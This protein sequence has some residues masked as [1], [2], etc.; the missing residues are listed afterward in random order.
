MQIKNN[1]N[2]CCPRDYLNTILGRECTTSEIKL[3]RT[4]L[5]EFAHELC[6]WLGECNEAGWLHF[7]KYQK[8]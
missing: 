8:C 7:D 4:G 3:I 2:L 5:G 1:D 6:D